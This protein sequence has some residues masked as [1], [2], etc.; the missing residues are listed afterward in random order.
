M[1]HGRANELALMER[2]REPARTA[3]SAG[4]N[5]V[6][7]LVT[8]EG[9]VIAEAGEEAPSGPVAFAH[10]E[11]LT[12]QRS[13]E[14]TARR[15]L[16]DATLYSTH[17]PCFLC[18]YAVR[19]ARIGRVVVGRSVP[20]I[21]GATSRYPLLVADDIP[22]WGAAPSVIWIGEPDPRPANLVRMGGGR[23]RS[24]R[25]CNPAKGGEFRKRV[26]NKEIRSM[27]T[28]AS[29]LQRL[30]SWCTS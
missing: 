14:V 24:T 18:S 9:N 11:L 26:R 5:E 1:T 7:A 23:A 13:L 21:G 20:E 2:C 10:A 30:R 17:E 3:A 25:G 29:I 27:A 15:R 4:N 6:G 8:I 28:S 12:I 16:P 19:A 22:S